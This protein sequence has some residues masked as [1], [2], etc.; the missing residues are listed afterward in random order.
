MSGRWGPDS[1]GHQRAGDLGP[2]GP[3]C[4]P[5]AAALCC[6]SPGVTSP[7]LS[8]GSPQASTVLGTNASPHTQPAGTH[9]ALASWPPIQLPC[10]SGCLD[11]TGD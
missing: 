8:C 10:S 1:T 5:P 9:R 6:L 7:F 4:V 2:L 11:V 3:P